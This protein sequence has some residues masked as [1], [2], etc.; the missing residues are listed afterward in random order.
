MAQD[1]KLSKSR[2]LVQRIISALF[3]IPIVISCLYL[4]KLY[5]IVNG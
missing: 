4:G 5:F 3:L 1:K 2:N